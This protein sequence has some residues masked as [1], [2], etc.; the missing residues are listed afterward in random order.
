M[1][2]SIYRSLRAELVI[3]SIISLI[4]AIATEFVI[5]VILVMVANT[6]GVSHSGYGRK[7]IMNGSNMYE[8]GSL[9]DYHG[10]RHWNKNTLVF[11]MFLILLLGFLLFIFYFLILS[12]RITRDMSYISNCISDIAAG[13]MDVRIVDIN[14]E[15]EIGEIVTQVNRMSEEIQRLMKSERD[16]LQANKDMI[17]CVAHDLRTPLT[18]IIGYLQLATDTDKYSVEER[19]KYAH[20]ATRKAVRMQRL[21]E[22]LFSYTKLMSGEI[23]LHRSEI[24][25]VK[26]VEQM[27]EEFYPLFMENNLEYTLKQNVY[28]LIVNVDGE[29]I[30]RAISN[31]ISNAVKYGKDGKAVYI[32]VE[33]YDT[34]LQIRVTNFGLVIP[35]ESLE[36]I[37]DKFY[38]VE[39]SRSVQTG[40][41][42]LGLNI[43]Q[44]I[45][46]L[47]GGSITAESGVNGTCF[48]IALPLKKDINNI[49]MEESDDDTK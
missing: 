22:D 20:I 29:L 8:T 28:S 30:A 31:L 32:E 45:A 7:K 34:E 3:Y 13:E 36:H 16:A 48:T 19:Q 42:G 10:I 26:L 39:G 47:H 1:K 5:G 38:R 21:I 27:T 18:S 33:K 11:I 44:E 40:G 12:R 4:L 9:P 43:A 17:A 23:S 24:D 41:T 46:V 49:K 35:Q 15:D 6:F 37:F 2:R 25:I 14:R